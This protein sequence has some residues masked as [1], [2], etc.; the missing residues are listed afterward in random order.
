MLPGT[1]NPLPVLG[2]LEFVGAQTFTNNSGDFDVSLSISGL[3]SNDLLVIAFS[4]GGDGFSGWSWDTSSGG[5]SFTTI[6]D[7]TNLGQNLGAHYLGYTTYA[8]G[9]RVATSG[10]PSGLFDTEWERTTGVISAFRGVITLVNDSIANGS[11]SAPDGPNVTGAGKLHIVSGHTSERGAA[12]TAPSGW[13][14]AGSIGVDS[15]AN[16]SMTG[17]AYNFDGL[18]NPPAFGGVSGSD[19]WYAV[20][21]VWA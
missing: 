11:T 7:G 6:E 3:R 13:A 8:G 10:V 12:L 15:A 1:F 20:T 4:H 18:S 17:L 14:L 19:V 9:T 2:T 5:V 16:T 21:S